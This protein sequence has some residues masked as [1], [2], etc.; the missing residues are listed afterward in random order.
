LGKNKG[1]RTGTKKHEKCSSGKNKSVTQRI[2]RTR[3]V[4]AVGQ[5]G[6]FEADE[7]LC[8]NGGERVRQRKNKQKKLGVKPTGPMVGQN[9]KAQHRPASHIICM[10]RKSGGK[11][12]TCKEPGVHWPGKGSNYPGTEGRKRNSAVVSLP[13]EKGE[14]IDRDH[15]GIGRG[16]EIKN[17]RPQGKPA[18][19]K[20]TTSTY[21]GGSKKIEDE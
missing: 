4:R 16:K 18:E 11:K 17:N 12:K 2:E 7:H 1:A 20:S 9:F 6:I 21:W 15:L 8:T 3:T 5:N 14:D 19:G 13:R 10:E